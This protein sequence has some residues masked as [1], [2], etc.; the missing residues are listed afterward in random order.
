MSDLIESVA[1]AIITCNRPAGLEKLLSA[2]MRLKFPHFPAIKLTVVVVENG[3]KLQ[4]E[5][6]VEHYRAQGLNVVYTH[7]PTPGISYARDCAMRLAIRLG[8]YIAFIDDDEYPEPGWLDALLSCSIKYDAPVVRGPIFPV[9]PA[10]VPQ[11]AEAGGFFERERHPTGANTKY[12]ASNNV[13]MNSELLLR[14]G[15]HFDFHFALT[16]G[17]DTLFFLQLR[18]ST[19]VEV[20]WCDEAIVK[21]DIPAN[22][23]SVEWIIRRATRVGSTMPH[24]DAIIGNV[25]FFRLR[26]VLHGIA[27]LLIA[28]LMWGI[29]LF[30]GEVERIRARR[31]FAMGIGMI[32]GSFGSEINEYQE[33]HR[34]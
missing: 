16:G 21:E 13:L 29:G 27:H 17:S 7:E 10:G 6:Q 9:F 20:V 5:G 25:R 14:S 15:V 18:E 3:R 2:L 8:E 34:E 1:V 19:G 32:R 26:W 22:R 33:R 28:S 30:R 4:A 24:Y 11:W 12:C 23:V 31:E